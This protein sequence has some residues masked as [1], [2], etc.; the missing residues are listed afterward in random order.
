M[1]HRLLKQFSLIVRLLPQ[2]AAPL[3]EGNEDEEDEEPG[4]SDDEDENEA[5]VSILVYFPCRHIKLN[6]GYA[7][8]KSEGLVAAVV[9]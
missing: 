2:S 4:F 5:E 9:N 7:D 8:G 6:T 3:P 1:S